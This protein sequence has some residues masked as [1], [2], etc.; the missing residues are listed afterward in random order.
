MDKQKIMIIDGNSILN[1]AFY[2]VELL[3]TSDGLHTNAIYGFLNIMYKYIEEEN[4]QYICVAFDLKA[5]TFRHR[6]YEGY[7]AKRKGMPDELSEQ[8]PYMK[9]VLDAMRIKRLELEGFEA[10]DILGS[11]SL[12][13]EQRGLEVVIV[14]GDRDSLQLAGKTTRIKIPRT[15]AGNTETEE[16]DYDRIV[17][18][19]GIKPHQFIDVKGLM[20]D[21]SDNIPGVPGIGEKTALKLIKEYGNLENL[22][23]NIDEITQKRVKENLMTYKEQAFLS[24]DLSRIERNMPSLC[25]FE[26]FK[27]QEYDSEKLFSIFER[28]EFNSFIDKFA[29]R[30]SVALDEIDV[31][32]KR[33]ENIGELKSIKTK[34]L[35]SGKLYFY[36]LIDREGKFSKK[37]SSLAF[38]S[39][40][41]E[42]WYV[43][44]AKSINEKEFFLEYKDVFEDENVKKYSHDVKNFI[45]YLKQND[46][47]LKGLA[48]DTMIAAY[49]LDPSRESYIISDLAREYINLRISS[50]EEM[51]GKG[52]KAVLYKDM[53]AEEVAD[54]IGRYPHVMTK[55]KE[56]FEKLLEENN[57]KELY[58]DI[59]LTLI[60]VLADMEYHGF[61]VN[62]EELLNFSKELQS[63]IDSV[64]T[65]IFDL[66]GEK[67]NINSPKQLGVIL[68]E[69]LEL[70][71]IKKTKT[72]YSTAAEVLEELK[73]RHE[74]IKEILEYRQLV[75]LN[76][77]YVEG[78]L[79]VI[80]ENT[81][82]IHSS[83][84]Q[85]VTVTGRI[86]STEPNLQNIPIKLEM[87]R[88]I[89][90]V[91][92]PSDENYILLDAD[93]SQ[94]ELRVLAHITNDENM[95]EAFLNNEDIHTS[96]ASKVF[97]VS[98]S[99]VTPLLRSR[100]KAVNFG[101]V[102]GIGDFS[103]SKDLGITKKEAGNYIEEYLE[104]YPKVRE[105]MTNIKKEAREKGFVTTLFNR[106]RY[107]PEIKSN[108]FNI[109]SF[110]ERVALN[111]PIQ[112]SA[113]DIIKIAMVNVYKELSKRNL[114]SKLILQ[115]HDELILEVHKE[116]INQVKKIV[117]E[118]MK[119]AASLKVPLEIDIN[120]GK[121]WYETK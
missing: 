58:Y 106:R 15:K 54:V 51:A 114:K 108:N 96:T 40:D 70:P 38:S 111:T 75:K 37:L 30:S 60:S 13:A 71:I 83:F 17:E 56:K 16:Y 32:I 65:R 2:G 92:V 48:F 3:S 94:I 86:S 66:A 68:F 4:P 72:G 36:Y 99:E 8:V 14:T 18:E 119:N 88:K 64:K 115:V 52:K 9:E 121:N 47:V 107:I 67:F 103:L 98:K 7:K 46:I 6:Q 29:L 20:G 62:T 69:K 85:T 97:G 101:I 45:V 57:Q 53:P 78:L 22:Y 59:E 113:A 33:V 112:G 31:N 117:E 80:N 25:E 50:I 41:E 100:A 91:F 55:L 102:Y 21:S 63:K 87:G 116:E 61:K 10:D 42:V 95:I 120:L 90:K 76:S 28:L 93:Y 105:Y 26:E 82:K 118:S 43:D 24:R 1:R 11:V 23:K 34:I 74:I 35:M 109:R 27:Y 104:K 79:G 5:P 39:G 44:F 110:G 89:R 81:G 73:D 12:C 49:I 84:N 19:Y 77:T